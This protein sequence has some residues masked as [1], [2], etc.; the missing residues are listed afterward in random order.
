MNSVDKLGILE[1]VGMFCTKLWTS[2]TSVAAALAG[3][4]DDLRAHGALPS[5]VE[6]TA[7]YFGSALDFHKHLVR[8]T[9]PA[10]PC[11]H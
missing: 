10:S 9:S 7:L 5:D 6:V 8:P 1:A 11:P 4:A 3:L 2:P